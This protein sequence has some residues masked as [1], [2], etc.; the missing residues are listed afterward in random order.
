MT[1][2]KTRQETIRMDAIRPPSGDGVRCGIDVVSIERIAGLL[3]EFG[4]SFRNRVCTPTE[5]EYCENRG[6]PPQHYAARWA[7]K[8]A[9]LKAVDADAHPV[10]L[11]AIGVRHDGDAPVLVLSPPAMTA[12]ATT[13][14]AAG[15]TERVGT[16]V[17]LSH[18]RYADC[19][20]GQVLVFDRERLDRGDG[21]ARG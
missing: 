17:S 4:N 14:G 16:A 15:E 12:A 13:I 21:G 11:H 10:P 7:A 6:S 1:S 18:D 3:D 9:F 20:A 5:R 8:E 19:A 2:E